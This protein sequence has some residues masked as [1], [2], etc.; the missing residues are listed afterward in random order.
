MDLVAISDFY[1]P[2]DSTEDF[3]CFAE[4]K[5]LS[6]KTNQE[7]LPSVVQ[8]HDALNALKM[9]VGDDKY[10]QFGELQ[11]RVH[12]ESRK[13][14]HQYS[15]RRIPSFRPQLIGNNPEGIEFPPLISEL[16]NEC[17]KSR[18]GLYLVSGALG[19]GKTTTAAAIFNH[20]LTKVGG[21]GWALENPP[22]YDLEG[23]YGDNGVAFQHEV[24][25]GNFA[26]SIRN[27]MRCYPAGAGSLMFVG[28]IRDSETAKEVFKALLN[29]TRVIFSFH[30]GSPIE[31]ISRLIAMCGVEDSYAS[32]I[33]SESLRLLISQQKTKGMSGKSIV[34]FEYLIGD[35]SLRA[36]IKQQKYEAI[37]DIQ[38]MQNNL[39]SGSRKLLKERRDA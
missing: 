37:K 29:G 15:L 1:I 3:Y 25:N 23:E 5:L 9:D 28:E 7:L 19:V 4:G 16:V 14:V 35:N 33:L 18:G 13:A 21:V 8:L 6:H 24:E 11:Y 2:K 22:E 30:A 10:I 20:I 34:Q 31:A 39:R 27:M 38:A 36:A 26:Y 32:E 17:L 12:L